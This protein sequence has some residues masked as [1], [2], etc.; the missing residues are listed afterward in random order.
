MSLNYN[1]K[2][3]EL[4]LTSL[5]S[6]VSLRKVIGLC[7]LYG[8][9]KTISLLR[10]ITKNEFNKSFYINLSTIFKLN[11]IELRKLLRYEIMK[12]FD[13]KKIYID[14]P[15]SN[16]KKTYE[17]IIKLIENYD[18]INI[19]NL[20]E[21][22]IS[23]IK[24]L[25]KYNYYFII[26]QYNSKYDIDKKMIIKLIRAFDNDKIHL[27]VCSSMNNETVRTDLCN[28]LSI[29]LVIPL[30][31]VEYIFYL[32]IGSLIRIS[33]LKNYNEIQSKESREFIM[34]FNYFG[35]MPLYYYLL[36]NTQTQKKDLNSLIRKEKENI[37]TEIKKFY[38]KMNGYNNDPYALM[39]E[40][41]FRI[42][43]IVNQRKIFFLE[44]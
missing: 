2:D 3:R 14:K 4:F 12:L 21:A 36:K 13:L 38:E 32:Y 20:I 7:G 19:F 43:S 23:S 37:T 5:N 27:I 15:D 29:N 6:I 22:I 35:N 11:T 42:I 34:Y 40:Q 9:R 1:T 17:A 25:D 31:S 8:T 39:C 41:I 24:E 44:N 18:G 26:D 28:C 30:F 10:F 16:Y 33:D